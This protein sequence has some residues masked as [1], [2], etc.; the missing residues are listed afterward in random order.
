[1]E[2]L[3]ARV[4]QL[5]VARRINGVAQL[6]ILPLGQVVLGRGCRGRR[7]RG[8]TVAAMR[9]THLGGGGRLGRRRGEL[10]GLYLAVG[11]VGRQAH[12]QVV[13]ALLLLH[14]L[15]VAARLGLAL[16]SPFGLLV[17]LLLTATG[18]FLGRQP[19][20]LLFG[21]TSHLDLELLLALLF[22]EAPGGLFLL[23]LLLCSQHLLLH[24][25]THTHN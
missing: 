3:A 7:G 9:G 20:G 23:L 12:G 2:L 4:Q 17:R 21:A 5:Q 6:G 19:E 25:C 14:E 22:L 13:V 24:T 8:T 15:L 1:M 10:D 11:H 18:G 16:R